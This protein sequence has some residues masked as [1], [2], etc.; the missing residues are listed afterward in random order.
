MFLHLRCGCVAVAVRQNAF[1]SAGLRV[2][3]SAVR[4]RQKMTS[5]TTAKDCLCYNTCA[6]KF[7]ANIATPTCRAA[8]PK[9]SHLDAV[10]KNATQP[11]ASPHAA[12]QMKKQLFFF[13]MLSIFCRNRTATA[14][15]MKKHSL[16]RQTFDVKVVCLSVQL[17]VCLSVY[18]L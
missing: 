14:P 5:E 3:S 7:G 1:D 4:L 6:C 8:S 17:S 2:L 13:S 11:Q 9:K 15:Q 12:P 10:E 16:F 18:G